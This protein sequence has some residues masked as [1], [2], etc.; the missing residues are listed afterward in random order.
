MIDYGMTTKVGTP[1]FP[2]GLKKP[3]KSWI[4]PE[5]MEG[6]P[7]TEASDVYSIGQLA[8]RLE[9]E[10]CP[11]EG[12][13]ENWVKRAT[14]HRASKRPTLRSGLLAIKDFRNRLRGLKRLNTEDRK[15]L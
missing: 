5:L 4:A 1:L 3:R 12:L 9:T 11:Y 6:E 7:A 14:R 8:M 10:E 2:G 15:K 13:L